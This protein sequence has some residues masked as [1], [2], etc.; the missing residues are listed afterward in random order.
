MSVSRFEACVTFGASNEDELACSCGWLEEDHHQLAG[1]LAAVRLA[2][3]R[4]RPRRV[5]LPERRAS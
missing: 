2:R 3:Q 4:R 5:V 1:E